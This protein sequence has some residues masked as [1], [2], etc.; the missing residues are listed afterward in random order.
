MNVLKFIVSS[1][2][3]LSFSIN[4]FASFNGETFD[5]KWEFASFS[6]INSGTPRLYRSETS[7]KNKTICINAGHG[8]PN[9]SKYEVYCHPDYSPKLV[10]GSTKLGSIT[11]TAVSCGATLRDGTTESDANLKLSLIIKD[12]LLSNGYNVLMIREDN[13]CELDNVARSLFANNLADCHISI[14][15]DSSESDKGA[16]YLSVPNIKSYREMYPVSKNWEKHEK[17]G[18]SLIDGLKSN[19]VKIYKDGS[20]EMD[21]VQMSYSTVPS[22]DL[23]VGDK[24]TDRSDNFHE[25]V[26]N[27]VLNGVNNF[28]EEIKNLEY[29]KKNKTKSKQLK[30]KNAKKSKGTKKQ[31]SKKIKGLSK[32]KRT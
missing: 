2:C 15:Y 11:A 27:G 8:T 4:S 20:V 10:S 23:E 14:H 19:N 22:V 28:F 9:G 7:S 32:A 18:K 16:F 3:I 17:L 1:F 25:N 12:K 29:E 31:K 21:L 26:A 24:V 5:N 6:Q 30:K 13:N